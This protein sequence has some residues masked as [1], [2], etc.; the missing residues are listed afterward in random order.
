MQAYSTAIKTW[1]FFMLLCW[2]AHGFWY[3]WANDFT[4]LY[5]FIKGALV[6]P[7]ESFAAAKIL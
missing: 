1:L 4:F 6:L 5:V 2:L 7:E 3:C